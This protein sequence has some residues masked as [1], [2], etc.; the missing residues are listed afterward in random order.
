MF[1]EGGYHQLLERRKEARRWLF[2]PKLD[3]SREPAVSSEEM[4]IKEFLHVAHEPPPQVLPVRE[5]LEVRAVSL[6]D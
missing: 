2:L 4:L 3:V 5:A 6:R 1:V